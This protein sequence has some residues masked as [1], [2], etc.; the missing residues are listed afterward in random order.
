MSLCGRVWGCRGS[1]AV[2]YFAVRETIMESVASAFVSARA[3]ERDSRVD[4]VQLNVHTHHVAFV[5]YF[6]L[7]RITLV[8]TL[9]QRVFSG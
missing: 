9:R 4:A 6:T 8:R 1:A 5:L 2:M 3:A 7:I